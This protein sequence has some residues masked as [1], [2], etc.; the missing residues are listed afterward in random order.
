MPFP[1]IVLHGYPPAPPSHPIG[2]L[3]VLAT[4]VKN[5][6]KMMGNSASY[7]LN[8]WL[9]DILRIASY[10]IIAYFMQASVFLLELQY[11]K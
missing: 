4:P 7:L 2:V 11:F 6:S 9:I 5:P 1:A 8:S 10:R 3:A